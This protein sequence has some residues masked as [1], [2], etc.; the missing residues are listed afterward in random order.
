MGLFTAGHVAAA[1]A[2]D[3]EQ[4]LKVTAVLIPAVRQ[5][6]RMALY[7]MIYLATFQRG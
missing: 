4:P 5:V 7:F 1:A 2:S 6:N 3:E